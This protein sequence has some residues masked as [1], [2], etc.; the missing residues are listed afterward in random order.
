MEQ[1]ISLISLSD[2]VE[3]APGVWMP[4]LG[5]GTYLAAPGPDVEG[6]VS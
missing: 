2:R 3:I 6:E 5:L 1:G 4:R